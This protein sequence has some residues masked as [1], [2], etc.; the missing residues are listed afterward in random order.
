MNW[1]EL[2][3]SLGCN[4]RC[5]VCPG[6]LQPAGPGMDRRALDDH[7]AWARFQGAF[8]AWFGGGEPSLHPDLVWAIGRAREL[9][10]EQ[11]RLQ[12]NGLRLAYDRFA[13]ACA[14]AGLDQVG[15]S[16]KGARAET[17]DG[18]TRTPG[19]FELVRRAV[20]HLIGLGV[21]VEAE[22]LIT[23]HNL[24]EL[25]ACVQTFGALG[26]ERFSFW[27]VSLHGLPASAAEALPSLP[28]LRPHLQAALELAA[29][30]GW[31]ATSLHTP[32]CALDPDHRAAYQ[33]SGAWQL[34]VVLPDG[35]SF[36]AE[37]SPMEGGQYPACC[38]GCRVRP[39]CLGLRA[40][41]LQVHGTQGLVA[42]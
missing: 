42:I 25:A 8:G 16:V 24:D 21:Q 30:S 38:N 18:V 35:R 1:I 13:E 17:H 36:T 34:T 41:Y 10:F 15:L 19:G 32:P 31:K 28:E 3:M 6:A 40:D 39:D 2:I 11:V 20:G 7:L 29:A 23:R 27:L 33:H 14:R 26:I 9:G 37:E 4:C 5:T 22:V 12:T